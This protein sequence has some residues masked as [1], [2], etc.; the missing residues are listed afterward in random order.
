MDAEKRKSV[1]AALFSKVHDLDE[2]A[3][4]AST[5][6]PIVTLCNLILRESLASSVAELRIGAP[7]PDLAPIEVLLQGAWKPMM[8]IPG[9]ALPQLVNR[10]KVMANLDIAR[11]PTQEGVVRL[12]TAGR[13]FT[14]AVAITL[15]PD[16]LEEAHLRFPPAEAAQAGAG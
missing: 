14:V 3:H 9:K 5:V 15:K 13:E 7:N 4:P 12:F 1:G 6:S 8:K 10:L 2:A 16:G 11:H